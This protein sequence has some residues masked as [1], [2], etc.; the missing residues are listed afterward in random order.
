[1]GYSI[2]AATYLINRIPSRILNYKSS[3]ELLH[4]K[5]PTLSHLRII[6]CLTRTYQHTNEKFSTKSIPTILIGYPHN[7]KG[8]L[9]YDLQ[10]HKVITSRNVQFDETVFPFHTT[11]H[12]SKEQSPTTSYD[13]HPFIPASIPQTSNNTSTPDSPTTNPNTPNTNSP[14]HTT[15]TPNNNSPTSNNTSPT[16]YSPTHTVNTPNNNSPTSNNTSPT[17]NINS[18]THTNNSPTDPTNITSTESPSPTSPTPPPPLRT[19]TRNKQPPIKLQDYILHKSK[20]HSVTNSKYHY[21]HYTNYSNL[22]PASLYFINNIHKVT[23]PTTYLQASKNPKWVEAMNLEIQALEKNNTWKLVPLPT[24]KVPI[25][26]KWVFNI[27]R[28]ADGNIERYKARVVAKRYNQKEGIDY[29]ETFAPVA[30]MVTV[31]TLIAVAISNGWIIEQLDVN[32]AFLHGDLHEDVYMQVPQGYSHSLPPNTVCKLTKSLYGLKQANRQWFEKLTTFL[33]S[34]GFKQSYV[35]TSLFIL[36]KDGKFVTLLVYVDDI[37]LVGND[38]TII[39]G[40][41]ANLNEKF[42]IKDLGPLHYYLGI[43]FFRNSKGLAITQK[44]YATDLITHA[45]LLHTKPSAIPLDPILKLTMTGGEPLQDPSLYRTLVGKLIYLTIIRPNLAFSAQALNQFLQRPTTLHMKGLIKASC[46]FSRRSVTGYGIF[47]GSSLISWQSKKQ[48][49]ISR[50]STEAE[51]MALADT[52]CE[53]TW[54][55]CLIKEF[56]VSISTLIPIMCDNAS[57]I[58]L[59][60]NPVHHARTKHI[61]IDCH[62]VRDKVKERVILPTYVST[63]HQVADILTKGLPKPLHYNCL[64]KLGLCN[65]YT[66]PTCEGDDVIHKSKHSVNSTKYSVKHSVNSASSIQR[67]PNTPY[68]LHKMRILLNKSMIQCNRM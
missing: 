49:V 22:T 18:P 8:Y 24:G 27:K 56:Q 51:Y 32:N 59:A 61:E 41:K 13:T 10:T 48:L 68:S 45:G 14:T 55:K 62:F 35:D 16:S 57:S 25:G 6:G 38:K 34:V 66:M 4:D 5:P 43:E 37:L 64:S 7:Q 67:S 42:S 11:K 52:T 40:I 20:L 58:A 60:S 12:P 47:L 33:I 30:K 53:V 19:S 46:P 31:R 44:K 50:S 39:Q 36:N 2:L 17:S 28:K 63:K 15:S 3:F 9:L 21:T 23:E 65:P 1:L 26:S 29:T 54:L